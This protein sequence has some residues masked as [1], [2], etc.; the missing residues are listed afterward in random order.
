MGYGFLS[1]GNHMI[2]N[3]KNIPLVLAVWA[4]HDEYDYVN[5]ENYISAT[6]LL[7]PLRHIVL[8]PRVPMELTKDSDVDDY[9]SRAMGHSIH[10][11]VEKAWVKGYATNLKKL[12]IADSVIDRVRIN[13]SSD[14]LKPGVIPVYLEQRGFRKITVNGVTYTVGGKFDVVAEGILHDAKST[15][16]FGYMKGNR[17]EDYILQGS[18]YRWIHPEKISGDVIRICFIF[19]DWQKFMAKQNPEYPQSRVIFKEYKL[20]SPEETER[21]ISNRIAQ[22]QKYK[23]APEETIPECTPEELWIGAPK[24]KYY[25]NASNT[26]GRSTK[27]FDDAAEAMNHWKVIKGGAGIVVTEQGSPKRCEYCNVYP[28]CSQRR[29]YFND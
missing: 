9:I 14:E 22:I 3:L 4:V 10:D 24:Y 12:G 8:A 29:K 27:N 17:D 15:G 11:S 20:M 28:I 1:T 5:E 26:S 25:A 18:I 16:T 21:W 6:A 13:P 2:T 19:T 7:K 23:A